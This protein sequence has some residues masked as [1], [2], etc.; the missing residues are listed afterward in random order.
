MKR[1]S[2]LSKIQ[3]LMEYLQE[4]FPNATSELQ[5][6]NPYQCLVAVMLSAQTTDK[7]VNQATSQLFKIL[8]SPSDILTLDE[9]TIKSYLKTLNFYKNKTHYLIK[10]SHQLLELNQKKENKNLTSSEKEQK[11]QF[12]FF[13]PGSEEELTQLTGI[14][15]K[16]AKVVLAN[17]FHTPTIAVD[18]HV[19]RVINRLSI[20]TTKT[21]QQTSLII[22]QLFP[23]GYKRHANNQ[24]VLFGRYYCKA[25]NPLCNHCKLKEICTYHK[26]G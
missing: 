24:I 6:E 23:E 11:H 15:I 19:H 4:L 21:P 2:K 10:L 16:T 17:V 26:K 14:G 22:N 18:T 25:K 8:K 5:F 7:S 3:S 9:E 20:A 12:G 1:T 13:I